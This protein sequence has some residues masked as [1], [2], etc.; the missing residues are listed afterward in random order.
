MKF[1]IIVILFLTN[2]SCFFEG[3]HQDFLPKAKAAIVDTQIDMISAID[4][5]STSKCPVENCANCPEIPGCHVHHASHFVY[6]PMVTTYIFSLENVYFSKNSD[7][8][9]FDFQDSLIKPPIA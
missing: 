1:F 5:T 2:V 3:N 8:Y 4:A 9:F 6:I 7:I